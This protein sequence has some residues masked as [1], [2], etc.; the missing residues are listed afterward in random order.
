MSHGFRSPSTARLWHLPARVDDDFPRIK[1]WVETVTGLA[2]D[3]EGNISALE[4]EAWQERRERLRQLGGSPKTDSG[5]LFDPILYGPD[6]TARARA[7][8]ERKCWVEAEAAFAAVIHARPLTSSVWIKRAQFYVMRS[9]PEKA[10]DDFLKAL[11]L[12]DRDTDLLADIV[13]SDKVLDRVVTLLPGGAAALSIELLFLRAEHL[14]KAGQLDLA[15]AVLA[16]VGTLPWEEFALS[17]W[18]LNLGER[19]ATLGCSAQVSALLRKYQQTTDP[20][21]ANEV[22]WWCVL[23]PGVVADPEDPVR[24]AELA[25]KGFAAGQK[26]YALNT[27]GAALYRAGR[28]EYAIRRLEEGIRLGNRES[29]PQDCVFLAMAHHRLGHR[30]EAHRW[31]DRLRNRQPSTDPNQFWDELQIRLL[32]SEAEAV[33]LYDPVFPANP[34]AR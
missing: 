3:D 32:R 27:L 15:R 20:N 12:R 23:A 22:A 7:W 19:F 16:R 31:L 34:F 9:Q 2:V 18:W 24:L 21:K 4:T 1:L 11:S 17:N 5:W 6:P 25:V 10:A 26:H 30:D 33:I 8:M 29:F 28:F 13:A 14:A